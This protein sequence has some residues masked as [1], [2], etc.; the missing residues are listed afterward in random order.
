MPLCVNVTFIQ[1]N[2]SLAFVPQIMDFHL[3]E[4]PCTN[5][6]KWI[7][8]VLSHTHVKLRANDLFE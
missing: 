8:E 3:N 7:G 4:N 6:S 1:N 5:V 2:H